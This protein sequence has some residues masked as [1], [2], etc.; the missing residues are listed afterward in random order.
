RMQKAGR[1]VVIGRAETD[2][3]PELAATLSALEG[4]TRSLA[5]EIGRHG[6]TANLVTVE[7]GAEARLGA[8]LRFVLSAKSAFL[9]AQPILVSTTAKG[10]KEPSFVR[11]LEKKVA[12]VT[13]AARGI[14]EATA[15]LLAQE[16]AHVICLDR[17]ADDGPTSKLARDIGGS[18]CL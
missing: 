12:L 17:P 11:P 3:S 13:G 5:K 10:G 15:R 18:V 2:A 16:G 8:V 7:R 14:G 4:F 1:V 9:S 6:S